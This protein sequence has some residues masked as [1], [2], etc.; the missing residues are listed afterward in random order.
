[1]PSFI[2][3]LKYD[4]SPIDSLKA[5]L[6]RAQFNSEQ[7][8]SSVIST[9]HIFQGMFGFVQG[10]K[11]DFHCGKFLYLALND[12]KPFGHFN[13]AC[14]TGDL[15]DQMS[16]GF[17]LSEFDPREV[18]LV[19]SRKIYTLQSIEWIRRAL[20]LSQIKDQQ[21]IDIHLVDTLPDMVGSNI[22]EL[23]NA[24]NCDPKALQE[25]V[26]KYKNSYLDAARN[27]IGMSAS[28]VFEVNPIREL[29]L[30]RFQN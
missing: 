14:V 2:D 20:F 16:N 19:D 12:A 13:V 22:V 23:L 21:P 30:T 27:A 8:N 1:M 3:K 10:D 6:C 18:R 29:D 7:D 5:V 15:R 26:N 9:L 4:Q 28:G 17:A 11:F 24:M 25:S